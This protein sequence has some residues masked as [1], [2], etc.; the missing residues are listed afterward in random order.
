MKKGISNIFATV[1]PARYTYQLLEWG[2]ISELHFGQRSSSSRIERHVTTLM[3]SFEPGSIKFVYADF[4]I[5]F[6]FSLV[7]ANPPRFINTLPGLS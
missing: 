4:D 3:S 7:I 6:P 1:L 5:A 2:G